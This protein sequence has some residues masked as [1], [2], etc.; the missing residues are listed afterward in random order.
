MLVTLYHLKRAFIIEFLKGI[1][2]QGISTSLFDL[3]IKI[4]T[5]LHQHHQLYKESNQYYFQ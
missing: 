3:P 4:K 1:S 5:I 2:T